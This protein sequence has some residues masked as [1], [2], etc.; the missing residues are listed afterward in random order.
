MH[1]K[2]GLVQKADAAVQLSS[3]DGDN[4][5]GGADSVADA[6]GIQKQRFPSPVHQRAVGVTE[7]EQVQILRLGGETGV[8]QGLL[9]PVG[10]T[11]AH[12]NTEHIQA[13]QPLRR[14]TGTEITVAGHL[15][16][17]DVGEILV[18]PFPVSPAVSQVE[19]QVGV[20]ALHG[21]L[22]GR[23]SPMRIGKYQ[24]L[25][26]MINLALHMEQYTLSAQVWQPCKNFEKRL[27][28]LS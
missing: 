13:Q 10:V 1:K 20:R 17:G 23:D 9:D 21:L 18:E 4:S 14:L 24:D 8:Q 22:H 27:D 3:R 2:S 7:E 6:A 16:K 25:H 28:T 12:E 11:V 19:N 5:V 26:E 15:L